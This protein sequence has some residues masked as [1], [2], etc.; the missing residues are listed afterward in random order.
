[1]RLAL[2]DPALV[3]L[4]GPSGA[5]KST[6]ALRHFRPT[7]VVSSDELRARIADDP[8]DQSASA[9]AFRLLALIVAARLARRRLTVV[10]ATN[11][12]AAGRRRLA[13][14]ARR[15]GIPVVAIGF[16][17]ADDLFLA[18]NRRRPGRQ[19]DEGI[20]R[21][22]IGRLRESVGR[23]PSEGYA[24]VVVLRTPAEIDGIRVE[25][26]GG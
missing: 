10:D 17:M 22:Q 2:P 7:E 1:M 16:D 20:V 5:G 15:V 25:R 26:V 6:F 3:L 14:Q 23:L 18:Y 12:A 11:L 9:D 8:D 21:D 13:A 4:V 24:K 19:V